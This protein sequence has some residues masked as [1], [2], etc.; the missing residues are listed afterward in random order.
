MLLFICFMWQI[1]D[2]KYFL[3]NDAW[4][5]IVIFRCYMGTLSIT[6]KHRA[7]LNQ[8][9][10]KIIIDL[11]TVDLPLSREAAVVKAIISNNAF[12]FLLVPQMPNL[13][14]PSHVPT[15]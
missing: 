3:N 13:I 10:K 9:P 8:V 11:G 2:K 12:C 14:I 6:A 15:T 5:Q 1:L 4:L 7:V